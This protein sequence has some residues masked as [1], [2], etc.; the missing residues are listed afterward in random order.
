MTHHTAMFRPA[1]SADIETLHA[2]ESEVFT[3]D[4]LSRRSFRAL[5]K[6]PTA[7]MRVAEA[8]GGAV[9]GY[10]LTLFRN[11][12]AA[13][14]L[15]SLA[16]APQMRGGGLGAR[17]LRDAEQA[18][19]QAGRATLRLE[20][21]TANAAAQALYRRAGYRKIGFVAG[22]YEN[23]EDAIRL[24]KPLRDGLHPMPPA[25]PYYEQTTEF[26]CGPSC[27]LMI[28]SAMKPG[29]VADPVAEV[30]LWRAA[31]TIFMTSGL[32]GCEPYGLAVALAR[33]GLSPELY[34]SETEPLF[35]E[36]VVNEEKRR[37]M[38]LAQQDLRA[39]AADMAIPVH[40]QGLGAAALAEKLTGGAMACVLI[41]GNRMFGKRTPHWVLAYAAD[42]EHI[43]FHDP[44]V[45]DKE[46]LESHTDAAALPAPFAEFDR[47]SRWGKIRL[48]AAVLVRPQEGQKP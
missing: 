13:G 2:I 21:S 29:Y 23:G 47:M 15:Y 43:F 48:R 9:V 45:E 42:A 34:L 30:R 27:L 22:Y 33:E 7:V 18:A 40:A 24:E 16:V 26:T 35:L 6:S 17:L 12:A 3:T 10:S 44:W 25:P 20:V 41:S 39:Q 11:G 1:T 28:L 4:R 19:Y 38:R 37:V 31:T 5:A 46:A 14:R 36:S 32:G 8:P